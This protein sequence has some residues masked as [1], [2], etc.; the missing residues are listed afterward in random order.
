MSNSRRNF[1]KKASLISVVS[2]LSPFPNFN[3]LSS[4]KVDEEIL[5]HGEF[6]YRIVRDWASLDTIKY[7]LL[8]CHEMVIDSKGRL[9]MIGDHPHNNVLI[10]DKSG[11]L[12]DYWGTSHPGGHGIT[13]SKEGGEDFLFLTDS[14][15]FMGKSGEMVAHNGRVSKTTPDGR[16][17][18]DIGHPQTIGVY[19]PGDIFRPTEVAVNPQNGDIY[20]ADGYGMDYILQYNSE[21]EYLRHWGGHQNKDSNYNIFNAHGVALDFRDPNNPYVVCTSRTENAFKFFSL[22]GIYQKTLTLP[23]M[24]VCRPVFDGP[25]LYAGVCWSTPKN[26][27]FDW[28]AHTGFVTVLE[29]DKVVSNPG[30]TAPDYVGGELQPSYQLEH[31]PFYHGHDVCLDED[32]NL[33]I[34]QWNANGS[35][36]I[37][38]QRV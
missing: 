36:P 35:P 33:Y 23:N 3:I 10:F 4:K 13:L 2:T 14:G 16:T 21:G 9:I 7:P 32:K 26:G 31:K 27:K 30:G 17:L 25:N 6:R 19:N 38:L 15:W 34:C 37:K 18:F 5:G 11:K 12:L 8:N 20:V 22:D 1:V 29:G 28:K 24:Y